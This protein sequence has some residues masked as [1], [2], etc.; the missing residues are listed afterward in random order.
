M[1]ACVF[2][3]YRIICFRLLTT[4]EEK[5]ICTDTGT[6]HEPNTT[7]QNGRTHV[8]R[9]TPYVQVNRPAITQVAF[10]E[11]YERSESNSP[12]KERIK[13]YARSKCECSKSSWRKALFAWL[14]FLN[15]IMTYKKTFVFGDVISGISVGVVHVPQGMGFALLSAVKP[16]YGLYSSFF[17]NIVY[18]FLG[19]SRHVSVGTMALVSLMVGAVVDREMEHYRSTSDKNNIEDSNRSSVMNLS[20]ANSENASANPL[21][22]SSEK[23]DELMRIGIAASVTF[24]AGLMQL[25][26]GLCNLGGIII[27]YMS[28][29]FIGGFTT[30]AACHIVTG[31][32][33][34]IFGLNFKRPRGPLQLPKT[35]VLLFENIT[36]T[37]IASLIIGTLSITFLV[38]LKQVINERFKSK[39]KMPIPADLLLVVA[40]TLISH[41]A[42]LNENYQVRIVGPIPKGFPTPQVPNLSHAENY[43]VDSILI[44]LVSFAISISMAK[45]YMMKYEYTVDT[46]QEAFAYG[47]LHTV[48]SFFH[49]FA[50]AVAPPR[51]TVHDSTGGKTQVASLVSCV[52]LLIVILFIGPYFATLPNSV[53]GS[54]IIVA[55]LPMFKQFRTLKMLWRVNKW[56][57]SIW[58]VTWLSFMILDVV[59]GLFVGIGFSLLTILIQT[60]LAKTER[61]SATTNPDLFTNADRINV[62]QQPGV[63]I[64][65][66]RG[67]LCYTNAETFKDTISTEIRKHEENS[68]KL[69]INENG[70][71]KEKLDT[72]P[73]SNGNTITCS[74]VEEMIAKK[75]AITDTW[76]HGDRL[77]TEYKTRLSIIVDCTC[78][79]Y[80]D[81]AGLNAIK[82]V[83]KLC[84]KTDT[85]L[86]FAGCNGSFIGKL[87]A[88]EYLDDVTKDSLFPS[89]QDAMAFAVHHQ[90]TGDVVDTVVTRV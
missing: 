74:G 88:C 83:G 78:L 52:L 33:A 66:Y 89:V 79:T 48:A 18:F 54:I 29:P 30:A 46:N 36:D 12:I 90:K 45:I 50:G 80:V 14:P 43:I 9:E 87:A 17:P 44:G 76:K 40:G 67:M 77:D 64:F 1:I 26:L 63:E 53:L 57:C 24:L 72:V 11:L 71:S 85:L 84:K 5:S 39:L 2:N 28:A 22:D 81:L 61:V 13:N 70:N 27:R 82:Q 56:D 21:Y 62:K 8:M 34:F 75:E 49:C 20:I 73:G 32:L 4:A 16:V 10:D 19:T 35:Y 86:L 58:F 23:E 31:Q 51:C 38:V 69:H 37:N 15:V 55:L 65:R 7:D 41:F 47:S 42:R 68:L 25:V 6:M 60:Q 59:L 3:F